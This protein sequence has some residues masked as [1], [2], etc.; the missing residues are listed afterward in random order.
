VSIPFPSDSERLPLVFRLAPEYRRIGVYLVVSYLCISGALIGLQVAGVGFGA[1]RIAIGL[2]VYGV[3]FL[4][5]PLLIFRARLRVDSSGIWRRRFL[6]W[7]L[8]PWKAFANGQVKQARLQGSFLYPSKPWW[9]RYLFPEFLEKR[10]RE[11]LA[12]L[13][14]GMWTPPPIEVPESVSLRYGFRKW[15]FL[16]SEGIGLGRNANDT[17]DLHAWGEVRQLRV[18]RIDHTRHDFKRIDLDLGEPERLVRLQILHGQG[19]YQSPI[20]SEAITEFLIRHLAA[21]RIQITAMTGPPLSLEECERRLAE[22]NRRTREL[23][24]VRRFLVPFG[25]ITLTVVWL[26]PVAFAPQPNPLRWDWA[27]QVAGGA[28]LLMLGLLWIVPWASLGDV[29]KRLAQQQAELTEWRAGT[30]AT[31]FPEER[32]QL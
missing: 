2:S 29:L 21:D 14:K 19:F 11:M 5:V 22:L 4:G 12:R 17:G 18:T 30:D 3:L 13:I 20:S 23:R 10:D 8:W 6:S 16:S 24:C 31:T 27:H 32:R 7:D 26:L 15:L 25:A 9:N 28:W 1:D